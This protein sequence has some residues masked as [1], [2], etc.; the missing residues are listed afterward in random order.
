MTK[1]EFERRGTMAF[2]NIKA[3]LHCELEKVWNVVT[4]LENYSWRSDIS[5]IEVVEAGRK[6][7]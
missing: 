5:K 4:S 1:F 2:A 7:V 6:F 3:V